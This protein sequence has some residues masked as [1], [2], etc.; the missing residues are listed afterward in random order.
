MFGRGY[1]PLILIGVAIL[2]FSMSAFTVK[3]QELALKF[4][5]GEVV[6]ADYKPGLHFLVPFVNN[7]IKFDK[8]ILSEDYPAEQFLTSEGK[9]LKINFFVKWRISDVTRFYISTASG[10]E[11]VANRRLGEIIKD[12]IKS[13]IAR[14]TIQ[15][16]VAAD[17][18]EFLGEVLKIA[19]A[20]VNNLG[21]AL[22]DVRV[23]NIELPE[24]VSESVFNRMR[25]DFA[26]QARNCAPKVLRSRSARAPKRIVSARRYWPTLT[27][28]PRSSA[29][30]AMPP[31]PTSMP[32]VRPQ[33]G[34]LLV[35][36]RPAG[37]P[38]FA[39]QAGRRAR[40]RTRR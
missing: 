36:P 3:E 31:R 39:R 11:E 4:K 28:R 20:N 6:N 40:A 18:S 17:R 16:V 21:I 29:V 23:K 12:G 37:V 1:M 7:V 30:K 15:Q 19:G 9:I 25:Q 26:R 5:W 24:E 32:G 34:V 13:V 14:R 38:A 33:P 8:R 27:A 2:L 10:S 22:V 35:L